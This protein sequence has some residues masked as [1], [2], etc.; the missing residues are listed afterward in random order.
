M[1]GITGSG[2]DGGRRGSAVV[3]GR[4]GPEWTLNERCE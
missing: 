1:D 4:D 2:G 3:G